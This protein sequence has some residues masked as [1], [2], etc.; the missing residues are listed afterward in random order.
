MTPNIEALA[1]AE[2]ILHGDASLFRVA[3]P[4]GFKSL[5]LDSETRVD[6]N[7]KGLTCCKNCIPAIF[8]IVAPLRSLDECI[9]KILV[10]SSL[11]ISNIAGR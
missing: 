3:H 9:R 5:Q 1:A 4:S 10:D 2:Q 11:P 7:T 6:S 8:R